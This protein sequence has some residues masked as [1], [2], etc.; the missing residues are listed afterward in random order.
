MAEPVE[1]GT[2]GYDDLRRRANREA[3]GEGLRPAVADLADLVRMLEA[4][5]VPVRDPHVLPTMR[6]MLELEPSR[7]LPID[8]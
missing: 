6:R 2:R 7:E 4:H 3:L 5:E 1:A 8:R